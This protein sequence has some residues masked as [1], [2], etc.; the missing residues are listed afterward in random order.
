MRSNGPLPQVPYVTVSHCH[1][2]QDHSQQMDDEDED[3]ATEAPLFSCRHGRCQTKL[4]MH[5]FT[6]DVIYHLRW[7]AVIVYGSHYQLTL[8]TALHWTTFNKSATNKL[9]ATLLKLKIPGGKM[10]K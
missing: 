5:A 4:H 2:F 7:S 1:V 6:E 3:T 9:L 8:D 10:T